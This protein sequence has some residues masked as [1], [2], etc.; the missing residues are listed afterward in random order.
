MNIEIVRRDPK[1]PVPKYQ[2]E[3]AS[4]VDLV[5]AI[6]KPIFIRSVP[7]KIPTGIMLAIPKGYEGIVRPRSG[8]SLKGLHVTMGTIDSDYRG[9][10]HII[11]SCADMYGFCIQ[12]YERIA[13]L[14]IQP[15]MQVSLIEV[16]ELSKTDRGEAG[17]GSTGS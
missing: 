2:T 10:I 4:C 12:P 14:A 7:M 3:G 9:E 13:Q 1:V 8:L 6:E 11:A 17:F 5:A 16:T 15:I